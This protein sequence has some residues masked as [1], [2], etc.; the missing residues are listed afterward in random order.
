MPKYLKAEW[1]GCSV[2]MRPMGVR[3]IFHFW[4]FFV[5]DR[6]RLNLTVKQTEGT[7]IP[8]TLVCNEVIPSAGETHRENTVAQIAIEGMSKGRHIT[9]SITGEVITSSHEGSYTVHSDKVSKRQVVMTFQSHPSEKLVFLW[10]ALASAVFAS[11]I[12]WLLTNIVN[13]N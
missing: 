3:R 9:K 7:F 12:T 5:G 2:S 6:M 4:P 1:N 13:C 10:M 11:A 8:D